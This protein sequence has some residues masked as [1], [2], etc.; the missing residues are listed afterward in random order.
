[1]QAC[2]WVKNIF[3]L[4]TRG[5]LRLG[6]SS[7][8]RSSSPWPQHKRSIAYIA[9]CVQ[10]GVH[11]AL[12][13]RSFTPA[14]RDQSPL[15]AA[16]AQHCAITAITLSAAAVLHSYMRLLALLHT[17]SVSAITLYTNRMCPYA[18]RVAIALEHSGLQHDK[19]EVDLYGSKGF[20]KKD[21]KA[22]ETQAGLSPKGYIP[23]LTLD[24][25][26]MRESTACVERVGALA[27]EKLAP[28]DTEAAA[29][30][31]AHCDGPITRAGKD[32]VFSGQA[33]TPQLERALRD[34]DA[35]LEGRD[36][37][38]GD[39][40]TAD[41]VLLPFLFRI[42]KELEIPADASRLQGY[43]DRAFAHPSFRRT[44]AE[45]YWWW[46]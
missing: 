30:A 41:C 37:I 39:F 23:V 7:L 4:S 15:H 32:A 27:P 35:K 9:A 8:T 43:L 33:S 34:L 12:R 28:T 20:T 36:Y 44:V 6:R 22:V 24:D 5:P 25:E 19:V 2:K 10:D 14:A 42:R 26:T 31:T 13:Y 40:S 18:Q 17:M 3:W 29:W 1:M 45:P 16:D 46:W 11:L 38:A 21:L